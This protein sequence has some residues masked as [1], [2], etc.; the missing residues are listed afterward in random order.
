[1]VSFGEAGIVKLFDDAGIVHPCTKIEATIGGASAYL[2][3]R[4]W[5]MVGGSPLT[6]P[7]CLG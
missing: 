4:V 1:M 5:N 7:N 6:M 3:T 2:A